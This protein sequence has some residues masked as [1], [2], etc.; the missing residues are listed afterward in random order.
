VWRLTFSALV[1]STLGLTIAIEGCGGG[2]NGS[3]TIP[4][5]T[6]SV[7]PPTAIVPAG[8][9]APFTA[10]VTHDSGAKG[11]AWSV[12]CSAAPCGTVSPTTTASGV[13]T[14]YTA[15]AS[16]P[17][18]D[19]A[20]TLTATSVASASASASAGITVPGVIPVVL[21]TPV[22]TTVAAGTTVQFTANVTNDLANKGVTWAVSCSGADCGTISPT[23]TSSGVPTTYTAPAA[24][25]MSCRHTPL[26]DTG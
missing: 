25:P 14:T 17:A 3:E 18:T 4:P 7:V 19:L 11:V 1:L 15:P 8:T 26:L 16:G 21:I 20:V 12:S 13:S 9:T 24:I 22:P 23:A 2:G 5:V 6:V 10:T